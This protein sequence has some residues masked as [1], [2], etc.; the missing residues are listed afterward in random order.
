MHRRTGLRQNMM[1]KKRTNADSQML[2]CTFFAGGAILEGERRQK[3]MDQQKVGRFLRRLRTMPDFDLL[4]E[5]AKYYDIEVGEILDGERKDSSMD[6]KTEELMLKIADY[7]NVERD[8]VSKKMC[9]MFIVAIVGMVV[10]IAIDTLGLAEVQPYEAIVNIALGFVLGTLLT[11]ALYSSRY[12][13]RIKA[14]KIRLLKN[15]VH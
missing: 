4:I 9:A 3:Y 15:I 7:N 8:S 14:A 12:M 5:L 2:S 11:G 1:K 13:S 6:R 10:Y